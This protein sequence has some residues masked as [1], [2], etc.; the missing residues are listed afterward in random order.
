MYEYLSSFRKVTRTVYDLLIEDESHLS[1][2]V[3]RWLKE[4][5]ETDPI[6]F[7]QAFNKYKKCTEIVK[8]TDFQY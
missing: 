4:I 8:F 7:R 6:L 5:P 2:Y 3:G 1:K